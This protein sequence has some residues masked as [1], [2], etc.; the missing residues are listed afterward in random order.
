MLNSEADLG[1]VLARRGITRRQLVK[2]CSCCAGDSGDAGA[3]SGADRCRDEQGQE[4]SAGLAAVSGLHWVL[5]VDAAI[6][7]SRSRGRGARPAFVGIPRSHHGGFG[8][9]RQRGARSHRQRRQRQVPRG[10]GRRDSD[11]G[12]WRLLHHWRP[13][14][15]GDRRRSV[16]QRSGDHGGGR[17]RI[18]WRAGAIEAE[19]HRRTGRA[20]SDARGSRSSTWRDVRTTPRTPPRCWCITSRSTTCP[21]SIN[22]IVRCSRTAG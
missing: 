4:A 16:P 12:R 22:T 7:P 3:L 6:E 2:Y 1:T 17:V 5:G 18:R 20:G 19:S 10:R 14:R 8:R 13:N 15:D 11:R 21:R 9:L